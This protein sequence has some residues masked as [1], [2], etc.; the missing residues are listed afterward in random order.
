MSFDDSVRSLSLDYLNLL[1][2]GQA[3]SDVTFSVEGRLVHAHRCILAARSLFFRK[4]FCGS[5]TDHPIGLDP[6]SGGGCG[7][8]SSR[9]MMTGVGPGSPKPGNSQAIPVNSVGY[10]V[11]MLLLQFLYSGQVSIVP[12]KH[13]PRPNCGERGC[14]HTHCTSAVDLALDTL[15]AARSFGVEQLALL[16]QKQLVSMVEKASIEDVMKVLIASRKQDMHQLW[17]TCSHLVAK[18]GLAPEIL[19]KH[20]PIDMV[21]KI[22]ELRLK[23]SLARRSLIPHQQHQHHGLAAGAAAYLEDQKIRRMR[24]ALDSSDVE[25]VKLMVMGEGLNLDEALALHYA[26]QNCSREVVKALLELG[27]ADVNYPAGPAGKTPLHLAAEMVSPDMVA[28][29]LDHQANPNVRTVDGITPLNILRTLTSDFLFRGAVPGLTHIE[30]NKLRLCLELVQSAATVISRE[31]GNAQPSSDAIFPPVATMSDDHNGST[32]SGR[33][34]GGGGGIGIMGNVN[35]KI[36]S[37]LVYLDL[38]AGAPAGQMG[39][40]DGGQS[41]QT[42]AM[43]RHGNASMYHDHHHHSNEF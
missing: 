38:C 13:E 17:S 30:P 40:D 3:F 20:L 21:A 28:V 8:F 39:E 31:E 12:Q 29:L 26:V 10:E 36:D 1:I 6:S 43:T 25:L 32:I 2:N 15:A 5:T 37:R 18:S 27:A 22:E 11:F 41:S 33:C 7:G 9:M 24:R 19:A 35:M 4:F 42:D 16:S 34:G 14:W 23:S